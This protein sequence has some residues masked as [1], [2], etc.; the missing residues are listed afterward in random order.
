MKLS[1]QLTVRQQRPSWFPEEALHETVVST[2]VG[3]GT[4][5]HASRATL[6][7]AEP[8]RPHPRAGEVIGG[9]RMPDVIPAK[10]AGIGSLRVD[11]GAQRAR[12]AIR[13]VSTTLPVTCERCLERPSWTQV[14][15]LPEDIL[16]F[17]KRGALVP[18]ED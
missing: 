3:V 18:R 6:W 15:A 17:D 4:E 13:S 5:R 2:M 1:D 9:T 12:S 10:P 14:T 16:T 8:A 7:A 11:C